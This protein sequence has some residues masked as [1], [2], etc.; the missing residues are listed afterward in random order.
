MADKLSIFND[1]LMLLGAQPL[2]ALTDNTVTR[3]AMDAAWV[4][5]PFVVLEDGLWNFALR[6]VELSA[7]A[8]SS[9]RLGYQYAFSEPDDYV[10]TAGISSDGSFTITLEDYAHEA[11]YWHTNVDPIY[12]RYVSNDAQYGM[13]LGAWPLGF[14][15]AVA[16][17][18]AFETALVINNGRTDRT[19]AYQLYEER[20]KKAK[21]KDAMKQ[22]ATR[23]PP[24][25]WSRS[26]TGY[27]ATQRLGNLR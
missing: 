11:G 15:K 13:D 25:R 21:G 27:R 9:P 23:L 18:M 7:D 19:E 1:A 4:T 22:P 10:N 20:L 24:G 12:V 3:R 6:T 26:R 5:A 16:A 8:D 14:S 17:Y 2:Q